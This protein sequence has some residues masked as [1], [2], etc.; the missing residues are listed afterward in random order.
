MIWLEDLLRGRRRFPD[1]GAGLISKSF[2]D[3]PRQ[4][5]ETCGQGSGVMPSEDAQAARF[6]LFFS[7]Y[8]RELRR[9]LGNYLSDKS[10]VDDCVQESFLNLWRQEAKG[11][12]RE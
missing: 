4:T 11:T 3:T 6:G 7:R 5:P 12:L 8:D 1:R 9:F 2:L 10:D